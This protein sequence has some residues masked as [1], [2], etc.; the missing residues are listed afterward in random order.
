LVFWRDPKA[1]EGRFCF[2]EKNTI[3]FC[4]SKVFF[5][6]E[7]ASNLF[8]NFPV[9][10][11]QMSIFKKVFKAT[12]KSFYASF[13]QLEKNNSNLQWVVFLRETPA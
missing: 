3:L 12:P 9:S 10:C 4:F 11:V 5:N 8:Q 1:A 6:K 2:C 13:L 7:K